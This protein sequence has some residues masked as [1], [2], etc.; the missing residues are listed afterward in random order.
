MEKYV[1]PARNYIR[2]KIA[3]VSEIRIVMVVL[4]YSIYY[5]LEKYRSHQKL[6]SQKKIANVSE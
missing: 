4:L 5:I 2:D 3:N 6:H 1:D